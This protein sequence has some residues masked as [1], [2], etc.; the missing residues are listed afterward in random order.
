MYLVLYGGAELRVMMTIRLYRFGKDSSGSGERKE[1]SGKSEN[2][3]GWSSPSIGAIL[4][5]RAAPNGRARILILRKMK[6]IVP[7]S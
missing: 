5:R 4:L 1:K 7:F 3:N 2:P 6:K